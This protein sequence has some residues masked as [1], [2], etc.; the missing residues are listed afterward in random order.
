VLALSACNGDGRT[1]IIPLEGDV[2]F[3]T[4]LF[5]AM[6]TDQNYMVSPF[7]LRMAL[8]MAANGADDETQ[9]QILAA[10]DIDNLDEFNRVAAEFIAMSN[11]NEL[12]EFNIANSIWLNED[13]LYGV[14][15]ADDFKDIIIGYFA[16]IA[17]G[18]CAQYGG[19]IVNAWISEQTNDR[20]NDVVSRDVFNPINITL[21]LLVNTIYFNGDWVSPFNSA[22]TT[23][24][25]FTDRNGVQS[26]IPIMEQ[27]GRFSFY[28]NSYFKMLAKP[29]IDEN[30]RMYFVLPLVE[31]RLHFSMFEDAIDG[32]S[33]T[34]VRFRLPRFTTES[35]H[36]NLVEV[37]QSMG[38][39]YAFNSYADFTNMFAPQPLDLPVYISDILQKTFIS[40]DEDGAEAAA[41]TVLEMVPLMGI[42]SIP[43]YCNVP[44]IYFIR[45][46][47][48]GDI[49][50][51]G[52]FAFAE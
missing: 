40:V 52:E 2:S 9:A 22:L 41:A 32:M 18:A 37:M 17:E 8:A 20:I 38:V 35:R 14:N 27:T 49:L 34:D 47:I 44:F 13:L 31:E 23:D 21:A 4:A 5:H 6:P 12:V 10:L 45:N 42:P 19:D 16:G 50:F 30:I 36:E 28:Q 33:V 46:D 24:C 29:S 43:F 39:D 15:F 7:S 25:T 11:A 26:N 3:E 48:T 51:M 1:P